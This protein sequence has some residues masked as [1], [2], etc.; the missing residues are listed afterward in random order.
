M[1]RLLRRYL[2]YPDDLPDLA[3]PRPPGEIAVQQASPSV[4]SSAVAG[5]SCPTLIEVTGNTHAEAPLERQGMTSSGSL[6][7]RLLTPSS[8]LSQRLLPPLLGRLVAVR[9]RMRDRL[10]AL[11]AWAGETGRM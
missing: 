3:A 10:R 4:P 2:G 5:G 9:E 8:V 1:A 11:L 7:P 6:Q